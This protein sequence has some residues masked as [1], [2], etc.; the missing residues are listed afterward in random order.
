MG[1]AAKKMLQSVR[2]SLSPVESRGRT[3]IHLA[4]VLVT[5]PAT[6]RPYLVTP[7]RTSGIR[8]AVSWR[9]H[10]GET[11]LGQ[12]MQQ[13][14]SGAWDLAMRAWTGVAPHHH[15]QG[16]AGGDLCNER[17][18]V[19]RVRLNAERG[20]VRP[21]NQ[22]LLGNLAGGAPSPLLVNLFLG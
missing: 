5:T 4:A 1:F 10:Q 8:E 20:E 12:G 21:W 14:R 16:F 15:R 3:E 13:R 11:N 7:R 22:A 17:R 18:V 6:K 19:D 2:G 9:H